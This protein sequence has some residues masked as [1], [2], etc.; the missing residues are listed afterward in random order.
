[1]SEINSSPE[2]PD[3]FIYSQSEMN[4]EKIHASLSK[5]GGAETQSIFFERA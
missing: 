3:S 5:R 2:K 1:M 4:R